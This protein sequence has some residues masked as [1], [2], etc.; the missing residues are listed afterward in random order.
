MPRFSP[1]YRTTV[2]GA[3]ID[4]VAGPAFIHNGDYYLT[5]IK[6]YRDGL[7]DCWGLVDFATFREKVRSG[8]VV[9]QP[10]ADARVHVSRLGVFTAADAYFW[11]EPEEFVKEVADH[12]EALN[13][14]PTTLQACR[15]AWD[16]YQAA[17]SEATRD[18]L[19]LAYEAMPE[20]RRIYVLGDQDRKDHP[21]RRVLFP[22][23]YRRR[24]L[25]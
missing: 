6:V 10:P 21:I 16:A 14:R 12:I 4:G 3:R 8:W 24:G 5:D 18:G 15:A 17:P 23:A 2:D 7:I 20:H 19:R 22:D 9:T 13:G 11:V 25:A 1:T